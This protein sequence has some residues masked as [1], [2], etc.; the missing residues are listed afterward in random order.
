MCR[1][2]LEKKICHSTPT[3]KGN[4]L[5]P[6]RGQ[7]LY[8]MCRPV[9][10]KTNYSDFGVE[11]KVVLNLLEAMESSIKLHTVESQFILVFFL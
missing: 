9:F 1:P 10:K 6:F 3:V 11:Y 7:I 5:L 4:N 2:V 8:Y